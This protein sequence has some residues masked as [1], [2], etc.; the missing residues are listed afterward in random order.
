LRSGRLD[1]ENDLHGLRIDKSLKVATGKTALRPYKR[2]GTGL[3]L[4]LLLG[5]AC[6]LFIAPSN[7]GQP[8]TESEVQPVPAAA[9][10]TTLPGVVLNATGYIVARHKIQ[11]ASKVPGKVA[12]IGVQ[13]GDRVQEHQVIARLED[14]EYLAQLRQ[15]QGY[16]ASLEARLL[17]LRNGS[18]PEEVELAKANL[19]SEQAELANSKV[20]L[21][22]TQRLVEAGLSARQQLDDAEARY[23]IHAARLASLERTYEL[24]RLGPRKEVAMQVEGQLMQAKAQVDLYQTQLNNTV[25]SAPIAGTILERVVEKG[26]FVSTGDLGSKGYVVSLAD[27]RDVQVELDI[28]QA[29]FARL[30]RR[31]KGIITTDAYPGRKYDGVIDEISP[32][33]NRQKATVQVKVKINNPDEFL[34]PEMN[35]RVAFISEV[36]LH[37]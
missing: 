26:E 6:Y 30:H 18:R 14:G 16:V 31:Q 29:E 32:V 20:N 21:T 10:A 36:L 3:A 24:A 5:A 9:E 11:V 2:I 13:Q 12:W 28:N 35:A 15:G 34:R 25:I 23:Q 8:S 7:A 22:R 1:S 17:E 37:E 19:E 27:L 4:I 33:A